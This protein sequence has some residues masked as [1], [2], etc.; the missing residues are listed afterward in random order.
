MTRFSA[1]AQP[2]SISHGQW[3]KVGE[4]ALQFGLRIA[5]H[6]DKGDTGAAE[7]S[8]NGFAAKE[9]ATFLLSVGLDQ[10]DFQSRAA[11]KFCWQ[12]V[13]EERAR[14][15]NVDTGGSKGPIVSQN[16]DFH[17]D[18]KAGCNSSAWWFVVLVLQSQLVKIDRHRGLI[19]NGIL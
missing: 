18:F 17:G 2:T 14:K 8:T 1:H 6:F 4:A 3:L 10:D 12:S 7:R 15:G 13:F 16:N 5:G 11:H 9:K 19:K